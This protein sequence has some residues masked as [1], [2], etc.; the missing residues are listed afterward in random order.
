M[1]NTNTDNHNQYEPDFDCLQY[2]EIQEELLRATYECFAVGEHI[3]LCVTESDYCY[4]DFDYCVKQ[5]KDYHLDDGIDLGDLEYISGDDIIQELGIVGKMGSDDIMD[6]FWEA[7]ITELCITGNTWYTEYRDY[8]SEHEYDNYSKYMCY[9][10]DSGFDYCDKDSC[11]GCS[12]FGS[13]KVLNGHYL[14]W[15][16][17]VQPLELDWK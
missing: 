10:D 5:Y 1:R 6:C 3:I 15:Q 4:W 14:L 2:Y 13:E 7:E 9:Q 16:K 11:K 12:L 8:F 17:Y